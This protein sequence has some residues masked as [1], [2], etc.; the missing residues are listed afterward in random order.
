MGQSSS[1]ELCL[2]PACLH[3][4][5]HIIQNLAQNWE[6]IDPCTNFY[7][8]A[9]GGTR[10]RWEDDTQAVGNWI[11]N[12]INRILRTV[13]E[14]PYEEAV[15][16]HSIMVRNNVDKENHRILQQ[17]YQSCMDQEAIIAAGMSPLT[18]LLA[19]FDALWPINV[20]DTTTLDSSEYRELQEAMM[21]LEGLQIP[22]FKAILDP[23]DPTESSF[24][25]ALP[26]LRDPLITYP[27]ISPPPLILPSPEAYE[28]PDTLENLLV[29]VTEIF[30]GFLPGL[31][32]ASEN[33]SSSKNQS[34][35]RAQDLAKGVVEFEQKLA[36]ALLAAQSE[37][38]A[39]QQANPEDEAVSLTPEQLPP[40]SFHSP[41]ANR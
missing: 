27:F 31:Q 22:T 35:P 30:N 6:K 13:I 23:T 20:D 5:S 39:L 9:C 38:A 25:V 34:D 1:S 21:F 18:K 19:D 14:S 17:D 36:G 10:E 7:E 15:E 3:V 41:H 26:D 28:D 11:Q 37:E 29:S 32:A 24:Q 16:Y 2:K 8:M 40:N 33:A 4:S 12:R